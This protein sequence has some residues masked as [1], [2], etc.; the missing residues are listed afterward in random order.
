M[1]NSG[2]IQKYIMPC[3]CVAC[4]LRVRCVCVACALRVERVERVELNSIDIALIKKTWEFFLQGHSTKKLLKKN[5]KR[6][7]SDWSI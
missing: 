1:R 5:P 4:A 7:P 2:F 3:V 6:K